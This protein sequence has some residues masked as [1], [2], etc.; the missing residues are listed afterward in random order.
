MHLT[1]PGPLR[2]VRNCP[3]PIHTSSADSIMSRCTQGH[4]TCDSLW[5]CLHTYP[6]STW[7]L[8]S[9]SH[10]PAGAECR[11]PAPK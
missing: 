4:Y 1:E 6:Q 11:T 5:S 3:A 10:I 8:L 7:S 9:L 2:S